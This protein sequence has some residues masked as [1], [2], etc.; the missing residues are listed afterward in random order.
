M[1][2]VKL[3]QQGR[4]VILT[5]PND[6][7]K[8]MG[9]SQGNVIEMDETDDAIS[10]RSVTSKRSLADFLKNDTPQLYT[11]NEDDREWDSMKSR[12]DEF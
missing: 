11:L 3:R 7:V 8:R 12:G 2:L 5:I 1:Q 9:W 6:I 4:S 10:L